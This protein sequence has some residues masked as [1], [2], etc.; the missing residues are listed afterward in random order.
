MSL[1]T[2][3]IGL[4]VQVTDP[5][6]H[7]PTGHL[8][9]V[10]NGKLVVAPFDVSTLRITAAPVT[11]VNDVDSFS[12]S[13][14]GTLV[15]SEAPAYNIRASTVVWTSRNGLATALPLPPGVYDHPRLAP[16]GSR[17]VIHR[18]ESQS[19]EQYAGPAN[20]G[21][22]LYDPARDTLSKFTFTLAT[23]WPLWSSDGMRIFYA[24]NRPA[25]QYDVFSKPA[26]GSGPEQC[27]SRA[28]HTDPRAAS[29]PA[30]RSSTR[31]RRRSA[32][33]TVAH[34]VAWVRRHRPL[35]G[36]GSGEMMP[37]FSPDGRWVGYIAAVRTQRGLRALQH[38]RGKHLAISERGGVEPV[39]SSSGQELFYR[40]NDKMMAVEVTESATISF[41]KPHVL[42]EGTYI[43]GA[44]E[45]QEFDV[46]RDGSRFLM[47]KPQR[48]PEAIPLNVIVNWF[49]DLRR[50]VPGSK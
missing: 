42:F 37:T 17:I 23:D 45:G 41:G 39:W 26:D 44:T 11:L 14:D 31:R 43:F 1:D 13:N 9:Q 32:K 2:K 48:A 33:H 12:F 25:T 50:R 3:R 5:A 4:V 24:S 18:A 8:A 6:A 40:A 34:V 49:D 15:Y 10:V 38:R 16:D 46:S 19:V 35:F 7:V 22:W 29:Q 36:S 20:G 21:L 30:R 28:P 47:L 27:C